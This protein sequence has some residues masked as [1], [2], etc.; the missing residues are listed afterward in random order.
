M[1]VGAESSSI[2]GE[3]VGMARSAGVVGGG[4]VS[5]SSSAID[6]GA[7]SRLRMWSCLV[8]LRPFSEDLD[9]SR[10]VEISSS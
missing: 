7:A 1:F 9:E 8:S 3:G 4:V 5:Q 6:C 2:D 10:L